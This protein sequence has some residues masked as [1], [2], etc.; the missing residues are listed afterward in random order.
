MPDAS[1]NSSENARRIRP[2]IA[3]LLT[4]LGW[5][6]GLYYARRTRAA[7]WLAAASVLS[8]L[9]LAAG[10]LGYALLVGAVPLGLFNPTGWSVVDSAQLALSAVIAV[11]VWIQAAKNQHVERGGA[12]RLWGYA[13]IWL[14][15]LVISLALA[16]ALRVTTIQPFRIPSGAMQP[17]LRV[18]DYI[19]VT[20]GSYG[21]SRYSAAPLQDLFPEG[22]INAK[23][24]R[25]GD[26]V[27]FRPPHEPDRDFVK[28]LIGMPGDR[29][30]MNEGALYINGEAVKREPMG[31][32]A[33]CPAESESPF[34]A[35]A[36]RE[37]LPNGVSYITCDK[38]VTEL[39]NTRLFVVPDGHYFLMGDDRDNSDDSRR[40]VGYVPFDNLIG[41][42]DYIISG[43]N[44]EQPN[45][46]RRTHP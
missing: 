16:M 7:L 8:G 44:S 46:L 27:V 13:A 42:M 3:A 33:A 25:R 40:S 36:Y 20:K 2:W 34:A 19:V 32:T 18:G 22:R 1:Q 5:G 28:R 39:D 4:F 43:P 14:T 31:P 26:I 37:T 24:P 11:W 21:Y 10:L 15:P 30:Q 17:T 9:V 38:G 12:G 6:L 45:R 23:A 29:I 35:I 41:R